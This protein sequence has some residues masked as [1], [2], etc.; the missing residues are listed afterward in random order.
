M[1]VELWWLS[2][3][4]KVTKIEIIYMVVRDN[5]T[6]ITNTYYSIYQN[7]NQSMYNKII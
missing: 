3:L 5:C 7:T 2:A 4:K 1:F 6:V